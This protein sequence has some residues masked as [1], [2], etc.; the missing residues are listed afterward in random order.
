MSREK[1]FALT[2]QTLVL[3]NDRQYHKDISERLI[4]KIVAHAASLPEE[5]IPRVVDEAAL[6]FVNWYL[7]VLDKPEWLP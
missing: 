6:A 2:V 3:A 1:A 5:E 4:A 7:G